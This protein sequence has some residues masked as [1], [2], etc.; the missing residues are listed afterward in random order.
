[1]RLSAMLF[2]LHLNAA[3]IPG[4]A[5]PASSAP[6][7]AWVL[8]DME[9]HFCVDPTRQLLLVLVTEAALVET[10]AGNLERDE[11]YAKNLSHSGHL[12]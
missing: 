10:I 3:A 12:F 4:P 8:G 7:S 1:M 9:L 5:G 2:A 6:L 11:V